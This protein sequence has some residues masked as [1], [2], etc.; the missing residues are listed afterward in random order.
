MP[1][2]GFGRSLLATARRR[3]QQRVPEHVRRQLRRARARFG[4]PVT[5]P[6]SP[7][8]PEEWDRRFRALNQA[9]LDRA[10]PCGQQSLSQTVRG[11]YFRLCVAVRPTVVVEIG[12]HEA[13]F[14]RQ[15]ARRL[16]DRG[17]DARVVAYEANPYVHAHYVDEVTSSGVE[18]LNL[19]VAETPGDVELHIPRVHTQRGDMPRVNRISS[20]VRE[21]RHVAG[22][23]TVRVPAVRPAD[24]LGLTS[25]DRAVL[26]IDVEGANK[27]VLQASRP[28]LERTA[29]IYIEV[30]GKPF[31][32]Q[33]W[34]DADVARYLMPM[35]F[36]PVMR[37]VERGSQYNLVFARRRY[38]GR[39]WLR[40]AVERAYELATPSGV[41]HAQ[42]PR[43][44]R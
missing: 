35:G 3:V 10:R 21:A 30:E 23:E 36:V 8:T 20:L 11:S 12:A 37:D 31:W 17:H 14:S 44:P 7:T 34:L 27:Q 5:A 16:A 22:V 2:P 39:P 1:L 38:L 41:V 28:L 4:S 24:H 29:L 13:T 26:W 25:D 42:A 6:T 19:A 43:D 18:Y 9:L 40:N 15:M 32:D 33:Q